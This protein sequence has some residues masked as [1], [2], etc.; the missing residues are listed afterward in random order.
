VPATLTVDGKKY[1]NVG[2][3]FRGMSSYFMV[4]AGHKRSLNLSLD[5]ANKKQRLYGYKTL[6]LLNGADDPSFLHTVLFA[7][8][9]RQY[10]PAPKANLVKVVINGESWGVYANAQQFNKDFL[11]ENYKT[12]KGARWKVKGS[13]GADAGLTYLG[14]NVEDYKRRY[15]IK[16][17]D[18]AKDW[19]ALV[20]LCRTLNKTP[21]DKLEDALKP[22]LDLDGVLWFLALDNAVIN[23]DGYWTRASD[24]SL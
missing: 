3:H 17:K 11:A 7:H 23:D 5:F 12:K 15:T 2:V 19:K 10:I 21:L 8:I 20:A 18:N 22:L 6:N 1:P 9:A 13:P 24:Y 16:S 14:E 4:P